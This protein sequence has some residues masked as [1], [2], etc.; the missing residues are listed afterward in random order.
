MNTE[1]HSPLISVITVCLNASKTIEC[2][3]Q[4]VL[5]QRFVDY[6]YIV[7][8]GGSND[9]SFDIINKFIN[10]ITYCHS[11]PDK[12]FVFAMNEGISRAKGDYIYIL[13]ADDYL[14]DD[15]V[16]D[17]VASMLQKYPEIDVLAG[18][19]IVKYAEP[20]YVYRK[21]VSL[22]VENLRRGKQS[23][24]QGAFVRRSIYLNE[25]MLDTS[26]LSSV[27]FDFFCKVVIGQYHICDYNRTIAY[28]RSGG[29]SQNKQIAWKETTHLV[30]RHFG[31][32]PFFPFW[33]RIKIM[34][35]L[36]FVAKRIGL[37]PFYHYYLQRKHKK[38]EET[39]CD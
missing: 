9:G 33:V 16:F 38:N 8:D 15:T 36:R 20:A 23:P 11:K 18:A 21:Y 17:D 22:S 32:T 37:F 28:F 1:A 2:T 7:L 10:C 29:I 34:L 14:V 25:G 31:F 6:E 26:L 19:I 13:N 27:D 4:S 5:D 24:H 3:I 12:G 35:V 30:L 39:A